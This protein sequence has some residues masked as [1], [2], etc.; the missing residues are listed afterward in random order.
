[1]KTRHLALPFL[2]SALGCGGHNA[3]HP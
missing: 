3:A 1:M 2:L